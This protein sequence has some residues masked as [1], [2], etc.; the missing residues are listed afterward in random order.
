MSLN[1]SPALHAMIET[2]QFLNE[3]DHD[4]NPEYTRGQAELI[5]DYFGLDM[6]EHRNTIVRLIKQHT[7]TDTL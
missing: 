6:N 1:L 5:C 4:S 3:P 2:A 7:E